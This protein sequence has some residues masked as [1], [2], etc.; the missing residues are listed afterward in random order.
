[1]G[2]KHRQWKHTFKDALEIQ[3][4]DTPSSIHARVDAKFLAQHDTA[5][6]EHLLGAWCIEKNKVHRL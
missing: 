5:D 3:L 1:M 6:V 2:N 4:G